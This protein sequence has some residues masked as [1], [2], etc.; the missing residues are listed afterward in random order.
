MKL[1]LKKNDSQKH[2]PEGVKYLLNFNPDSYRDGIL[3]S[4]SE[5]RNYKKSCLVQTAFLVQVC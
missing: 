1:L 3:N 5:I 2:N 4:K